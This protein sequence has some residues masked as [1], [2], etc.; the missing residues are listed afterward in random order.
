MK[1]FSLAPSIM[2][3]LSLLCL[4]GC[5]SLGLRDLFAQDQVPPAVKSE[6][7]LVST[8]P[9]TTKEQTW[10]RLG[11]VPFKPKDFSPQIVNDHYMNELEYHRDEAVVAK[12]QAAQEDIDM[13]SSVS[14]NP[15]SSNVKIPSQALHPPQLPQQPIE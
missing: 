1:S 15:I 2:C 5:D 10:P 14:S 12:S 8:I 13:T 3:F 6:P 11:D 7:M 4:S 9:P